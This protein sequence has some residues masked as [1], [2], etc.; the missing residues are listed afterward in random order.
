MVHPP[1]DNATD[2]DIFAANASC[3][4]AAESLGKSAPVTHEQAR[5]PSPRA[6]YTAAGKRQKLPARLNSAASTDRPRSRRMLGAASMHP[7]STAWGCARICRKSHRFTCGT[8]S[9]GLR[10]LLARGPPGPP[11]PRKRRATGGRRV[12]KTQRSRGLLHRSLGGRGLVF[13]HHE[14]EHRRPSEILRVRERDPQVQGHEAEV[15][16]VPGHVHDP[17]AKAVAK[18]ILPIPP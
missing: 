15:H 7:Q 17:S 4:C 6:L 9:Y 1:I 5:L 14:R 16:I 8:D 11:R 10:E 3:T 18:H 12:E 2:I 13:A